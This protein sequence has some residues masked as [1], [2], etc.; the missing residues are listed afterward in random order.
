MNFSA[1]QR[2]SEPQQKM[3]CYAAYTQH[4]MTPLELSIFSDLFQLKGENTL[5]IARSLVEEEMLVRKNSWKIEDY[6]IVPF[7]Q[8]RVLIWMQEERPEWQGNLAK[9]RQASGGKHASLLAYHL[10]RGEWPKFTLSYNEEKLLI[11]VISSLTIVPECF[12]GLARMPESLFTLFAYRAWQLQLGFDLPEAAETIY[13]MCRERREYAH[14]DVALLHEAA[15]YYYFASGK[16][17]DLPEGD[18]TT[19]FELQHKAFVHLHAGEYAMAV[20]TLQRALN[21]RN[22]RHILKAFFTS[23]LSNYL[24][25]MA[26]VLEGSVR[27]IDLLSQLAS[28]SVL[29]DDIIQAAAWSIAQFFSNARGE[30]TKPALIRRMIDSHDQS[31]G[32]FNEQ[33]GLLLAHRLE[34]D[35]L[36]MRKFNEKEYELPDATK[37]SCRNLL[38]RHELQTLLALPPSECEELDNLFGG[39]P[40][41]ASY[42]KKAQWEKILEELL[43]T[44]QKDLETPENDFP[45]E[46]DKRIIYV[47]SISSDKLSIIEQRRQKN[48]HW[49]V[50]RAV[51]DRNLIDG[52]YTLSDVDRRIWLA[53]K[54]SNLYSVTLNTAL[55][56]LIGHPGLLFTAYR[57]EVEIIEEKPYIQVEKDAESISFK[58]NIPESLYIRLS[59]PEER[60]Y[61]WANPLRTRLIYYPLNERQ[62]HYFRLLL[63]LQHVPIQAEERLKKLFPMINQSVELHSDMIEGG[64]PLL[65]AVGQAQLALQVIP[66]AG[67]FF[68]LTLQCR[69]LS[70]GRLSFA[71]GEGQEFYFDCNNKGR[72][73]VR[74]N[75]SK[76]LDHVSS[77]RSY[78][79]ENLFLEARERNRYLLNIDE[80]LLLMEFAQQNADICFVEWPE[81]E[82]VRLSASLPSQ[83]NLSLSSGHGGWFDIEGE[84]HVDDDTVLNVGQ[85]LELLGERRSRFIRIGE[86]QYIALSENLRRQLQRIEAIAQKTARSGKMRIPPIGAGIIGEAL[87]GE[88]EIRHPRKLDE[89]RVRIRQASRQTFEVPET[90]RTTLRDYQEEGFRW[91]MRLSYWG[92]GACLADD[93]GLGKTIQT[94]AFLLAKAADG[95]SLVVAPTSVVPNWRK[96]IARFAPG[97]NV[98]VL[99]EL[100]ATQRS[101]AIAEQTQQGILLSTYGL[102]ISEEEA[103]VG[104]QWNAIVLDEAH[105]IKNSSTKTSSVCMQLRSNSRVILTG[106]PIQNHLGELWNLFQFIN[107]GLLGSAESFRKKFI[108]PIEGNHDTTRQ[109]QLKRIVQPFMLR[110]TKQEVVS[111]LPDKEEITLPIEF[112]TEEMAIYEVFRRQAKAELDLLNANGEAISVNALAMITRLRMAACAAS[113][114]QKNWAGASSKL[115]R[116]V[117][118]VESITSGTNNRVLVFS[119]FTSFLEMAR[120]RLDQEGWQALDSKTG[121]SV[122]EASSELRYLYL[123]GSSSIEQRSRMVD[124]FQRGD[125]SLFLISLKAGGVGLNLTGANY[126][127]HLDPWWNPAIEQQATDR[128]YRIGQQQKVTVYHLISQHTIEEKIVRLHQTKRDLADSL[129]QGTDMSHKLSAAEL[130]EMISTPDKENRL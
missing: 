128:A 78:L 23:P 110:R 80:L 4:P 34:I 44:A 63:S 61:E 86:E 38:L 83:W 103:F 126:V 79:D 130:I 21:E 66:S 84:V 123:D 54:N 107:P 115:D 70:G 125:C 67:G 82:R 105:S 122:S 69:P 74:R 11:D 104:K 41:L 109:K 62:Q 45:E 112:S 106:T 64:T 50:G 124:L 51:S 96:E 76:E 15:L 111:E 40:L 87:N 108:L 60:V 31:G 28:K 47:L 121:K 8:V 17:E 113:L 42:R 85:L 49:S 98:T 6:T 102:L 119:Q 68:Q 5:E 100:P 2:L 24:L 13:R 114:A 92:A 3:L 29:A 43:N 91:M 25:T 56:Y 55:P 37:L 129:L 118:L 89:L 26:Y 77:I 59:R 35:P 36:Q 19:E 27:S 32:A 10:P 48:G 72:F 14:D 53:Y 99:N 9:A 30:K 93:M 94:I 22:R 88:I 16:W 18:K 57:E 95:P 58:S 1:I 46:Q 81:G 120:Q 116:F 12:K 101:E 20:D 52:T 65:D 127:I 75:L 97:L 33:L 117:S 90:L 73:R 39:G 71:P 7:Y